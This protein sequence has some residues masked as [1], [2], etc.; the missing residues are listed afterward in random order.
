MI[1]VPTMTGS[2]DYEWILCLPI[3][4]GPDGT[5]IGVF[6]FAGTRD[7]NTD[8]TNQL[9]AFA[10]QIA[11]RDPSVD[12]DAFDRFWYVLN[13]SFWYGLADVA[14][15]SR[16]DHGVID[17]AEECSAAFFATGDSD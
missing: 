16:L 5:A 8:T 17:M 4:T 13:A 10:Q 2:R 1:R 6:G 15:A 3:L 7:H 14:R 9:A 12:T 11:Q